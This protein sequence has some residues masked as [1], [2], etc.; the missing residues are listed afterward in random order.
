ME[1]TL[2]YRWQKNGMALG[3]IGAGS[4]EICQNG[5]LREWEI[6]NMGKWGSPDVR[7]QKKL[8]DYDAHVLPFTVRAKLAGKAPVVRR[9][10]HDR[11]NGEFRSLMYSWYKEIEKIRWN[12]DFPVCR[13]QYEDSGL[14]IK[15]EA[16]FASPFVPGQE[17]LAGTP[18]FYVTFTITNPS[19]QEAEVSILGKLKNP[20]NRGMEQRRLRNQLTTEKGCAQIVMKSDSKKA[21]ASNGS[22]AWSVSAD[23]VSWIL[24]EFEPYFKNYVMN[25]RFGVTEES[26]LF[27]FRDTGKLPNLGTE[28]LPEFG[29]ELTEEEI[30]LMDEQELD[31]LFEKLLQIACVRHPYDRVH[32]FDE[33]LLTQ[34]E[35]KREFVLAIIRQLKRIFPDENGQENWGDSALC[36]SCKL[37]PGESRE[38]RFAVGW[39]FP[40]HFGDSGRFEGHWYAKRFSDAGEVVAYLNQEREAILPAVKAFSALLKNTSMSKEL[41]DAWSDHLS[42]LIKCSWW[43]KRGEFGMWEGSC[44]FHTTDITYQGSFGILA[45]FPDL[46]KKQMEMGAKFQRGDGRVHHFFTPD[47]S[48]VDNGYD[49]VDMNPQF[50]LLVCRDYLWTGDREYLAR[51]WPHIEK[52]MD[53]TQL[54]DGDG[55]GLPDH[56]TRANT[57][58]AWAMQGTPAYIASL[59]L[60]A[61]KAAVRMAQDL[62]TQDRAAAWEA[63]LEKGSKAFVEKLWNGRYFSLWA[64]GDKQDDCCMTDQIDGQ[65]Y[66]RLLGLGNFLPQDKID[67]ATDCILSENF[68]PESGLVNASYPAQAPPTLYT[69]KN[70]QMESNWSGIE[71]SF[72]SFLLENGRYKEAAQI[73]ETVE[74]R[75]TQNGRRFNHEE[76]GEH[77]YRALASWAVLQ[78]L[79]GL[80]ADMPREK[81]SFSPALPELT[82]PWFVPGAYGKLS[83]ADNKI[84]IECLG[85]SMKLKQL[86]IRT[87]M[88]KAV[89]T[90]M[91]AAAENAAGAAPCVQTYADGFLTLEF[92]DGLKLCSGIGVEL[93]VPQNMYSV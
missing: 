61:L 39:H 74:R 69:W 15:I 68:R 36:G 19:D 25:S 66:A 63:L 49:R 59:W 11:D 5:E 84:R 6:C 77:Y 53:N 20:V 32:R 57:Y 45:L 85:G 52:A 78:S 91:G 7:K 9:L 88:E 83:I 56:D 30:S 17:A 75:H 71:Y 64:D 34:P 93:A 38:I 26:Y 79:T 18:G 35:M 13:L 62:G 24:G 16:E 12:P 51:M 40:N 48:G 8:Y 54:L 44:G 58:D 80:K 55:D 72:A 14:P 92:A 60:A 1:G 76:C 21:N 2:D 37:A 23:E 50:V 70:V 67:T 82:A 89:V 42:T 73:V 29:T 31:A 4:V 90:T 22:L 65:W 87:G 43:T 3:G 81:L 47:L 46:Q 33:A 86:G 28:T 10:C 41:A 27:D